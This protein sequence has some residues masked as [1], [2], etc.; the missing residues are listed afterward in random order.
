[1]AIKIHRQVWQKVPKSLGYTV[2]CRKISTTKEIVS[3]KYPIHDISG[4]YA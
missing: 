4:N 1:M 3:Q 2:Y